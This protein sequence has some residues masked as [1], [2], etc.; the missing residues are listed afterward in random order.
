MAVR[1]ASLATFT[2]TAQ[3]DG[4]LTTQTFFAAV[5]IRAPHRRLT[6]CR[7]TTFFRRVWR[8]HRP[9]TPCALQ[10]RLLLALHRPLWPCRTRM[11]FKRRVRRA[12]PTR[13]LGTGLRV[14]R[15]TA[16]LQR[17]SFALALAS[18]PS[19]ARS[20][21]LLLPVRNGRALARLARLTASRRSQRIL[22]LVP[23]RAARPRA[24]RCSPSL[25]RCSDS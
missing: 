14:L 5:A 6:L 12:T 11:G 20:A 1:T 8:H 4:V 16:R 21:T 17:P 24:H 9:S 19:A 25:T 10:N 22:S 15:R 18:T 23:R 3:A 7:S 2:P 13:R